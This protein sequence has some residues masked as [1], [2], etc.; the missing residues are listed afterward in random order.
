MF[1][2]VIV[3]TG[4]MGTGPSPSR[5][6]PSGK[7][8]RSPS[9]DDIIKVCFGSLELYFYPSWTVQDTH[10]LTFFFFLHVLHT[11]FLS[12][13]NELVQCE[14]FLHSVT[15]IF[16]MKSVDINS[17]PGFYSTWTIRLP[18]H[19]YCTTTVLYCTVKC[20]CKCESCDMIVLV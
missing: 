14:Y 2:I 8:P 17:F 4:T 6:P 18:V 9:G 12:L 7:S 5:S 15:K 1:I 19:Q 11:F 20:L 13:T 10:I 16:I 3:F